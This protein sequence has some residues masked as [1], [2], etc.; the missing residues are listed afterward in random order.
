MS[1]SKRDFRFK[2]KSAPTGQSG[3]SGL[4]SGRLKI[5]SNAQ[6]G[7]GRGVLDA[8]IELGAECGGACAEGRMAEDGF[9]P[10]NYPVTE[11]LGEDTIESIRQN[12]KESDGTAII[13]FGDIEEE[14]EEALDYC[15]QLGKPYRLI[16]GGELQSGQAAKV[17]A[18]FIKDKGLMTLHIIGPKASASDRAHRFGYEAVRALLGLG[19]KQHHPSRPNIKKTLDSGSVSNG[20]SQAPSGEQD[21][22]ASEKPNQSKPSGQRRRRGTGRRYPRKPTESQADLT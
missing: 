17:I 19:P 11:L 20:S 18:D 4:Q 3:I 8:A 1:R 15:V 9:I 12:V 14:P 6:T 21:G 10:D 13:Y 22:D 7:V 2:K 16:D 5:V